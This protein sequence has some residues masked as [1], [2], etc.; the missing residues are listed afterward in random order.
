MM[1]R[2]QRSASKSMKEE[3]E[4]YFLPP[5]S[6]IVEQQKYNTIIGLPEDYKPKV[7]ENDS[8]ISNLAKHFTGG[9]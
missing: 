7:T 3:P 5:N 2:A 4:R 1:I 8:L 6:G 9:K